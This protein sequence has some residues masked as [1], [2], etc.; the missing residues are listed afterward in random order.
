MRRVF[1]VMVLIVALNFIG[2][3]NVA[4]AQDKLLS[5]NFHAIAVR[6]L[7]QLLTANS[8]KNVIISD[9]V[10]GRI[11][12]NLQHVGWQEALNMVLSMQGLV[13]QET[14]NTLMITVAGAGENATMQL[15]QPTSI[16]HLHYSQAEDII[17]LLGKQKNLLSATGSVS[18]DVRTNSILIQDV[19][20]RLSAVWQFLKTVDVPIQQLLIEGRI[21]SVDS[22]YTHE[23]GLKFGSLAASTSDDHGGKKDGISMDLPAA[24]SDPGHFNIALAKLGNGAILDM[25]LSALES[26]GHA[27]II[28]SPKLLTANNKAAYIESGQE[29]PYQEKT[30]SG[31]TS[32]AFKKAVLSLKV[33]PEIIN[34]NKILL[35]LQLNQDKLSSLT[36]EGVPAI[37]TQEIKTDV[38]VNDRQTL[39]LG[40]I[41]EF[42]QTDNITKVPLLGDIPV[43]GK[44]FQNKQISTQRKELLIF[45][46]PKMV[47]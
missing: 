40:G 4:R 36:V 42:S 17:N 2:F 21:V 37:Q 30:S 39:I 15:P 11:S 12:L 47:E 44:L 22:N 16:F 41:Y 6:D 5:L 34:R 35:H 18:A 27:N 9:K 38:E 23:L 8:G 33:T 26:E 46:S 19:P 20:M 25:T 13:K 7:L 45:V 3:A 28:S 14:N 31:A 29:I 1:V 10:S 24:A 43:L 32:V